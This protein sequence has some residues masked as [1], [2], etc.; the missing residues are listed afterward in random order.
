MSKETDLGAGLLVM[1][2]EWIRD[3]REVIRIQKQSIPVGEQSTVIMTRHEC[4]G[5]SIAEK[6]MGKEGSGLSKLS[7][8]LLGSFQSLHSS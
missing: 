6:E 4:T 1:E 3:E 2:D 5:E 8:S 7:S